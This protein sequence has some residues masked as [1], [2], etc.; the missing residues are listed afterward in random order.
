MARGFGNITQ[1]PSK[2]YRARYR[3]GGQWHNAPATFARKGDAEA[4][5]GTE[6]ALL[7]SG[8]WA[9][10]AVRAA[11]ASEPTTEARTLDAYFSEWV[12]QRPVKQRTRE[13]YV[14]MWGAHVA[15]VLGGLEVSDL[16]P[17]AVRAWYAKCAPGRETTRAH[18]YSILR[19]L[20]KDAITDGLL[21]ANPCQIRGAGDSKRRHKVTILDLA[22]LERLTEAM[23][24]R[25]RAIIPIATWCGLR[26]GE[27]L[28]LRRMDINLAHGTITIARAITRT[29]TGA[30]IGDPK[31]D[32]GS[33]T[34]TI[35]P[36]VIPAIAEHLDNHV[37]KSPSALLFYS[38][39][40]PNRNMT[41][42]RLYYHFFPARMSIMRPD[43][44]FHD[45]RH[46]GAT[47]AAQ[48]GATLPELMQRLGHSSPRAA[49][50]Y[51]H[52][53]EDRSAVVAARMSA[54]LEQG[55]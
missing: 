26:Q 7:S 13:H 5:L 6:R 34:V 25:L 49:L 29:K 39:T 31:S 21:D 20:C 38:S 44:R 54:M 32:A 41:H 16:T 19:T 24:P 9:P 50:I 42:G 18:A 4:W 46:T 8:G 2:R 3:H 14:Y 51:Q 43:L 15:P 17:A 12:E 45:L 37:G 27:I 1:L 35:P 48:A 36:H 22:D 55:T 10:P 47:L 23:P 30:V 52:V 33:R 28:E 40:D 11:G 53:A